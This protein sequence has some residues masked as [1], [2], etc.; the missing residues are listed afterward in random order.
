MKQA[1]I[2]IIYLITA[3]LFT[4]CNSDEHDDEY[5]IPAG[6]GALIVELR[7][8]ALASSIGDIH[9]F[10][11]ESGGKLKDRIY[12]ESPQAVASRYFNFP[13]GYYTVIAVANAGKDFMPDATDITLPGFVAKLT[14]EAGDYPDMISG[15]A[16]ANLSEGEVKRISIV[17]KD[18]ATGISLSTLRLIL[19]LPSPHLP[20]YS[21]PRSLKTSGTTYALRCVIEACRNGSGEILLRHENLPVQSNDGSERYIVELALDAGTHN[22]RIWTDYVPEGTTA[23]HHYIAAGGLKTVTINTDPYRANTDSRNAFYAHLS[24][25][26]LTNEIQE[27]TVTMERPLAKYRL[28]ATDVE[29]YRQLVANNNYPPLD[30]LTATIL[31]EGFVPSS[32]NVTTGSPN[33]AIT[34]L[35]YGS[36]LPMSAAGAE[37]MQVGS[38]WVLVNGSETFVN[39][40]VRI[41]DKQ[42]NIVSQISGVRIN[43]H[44]GYLTTV[45]GQFLTAGKTSGGIHIDT[46]WEDDIIIEF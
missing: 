27:E 39:V 5:T 22:I 21:P 43:Y 32:F 7:L 16:Q 15:M 23:D 36:E 46:D 34:G 24:P 4:A 11:F 37:Q 13:A 12:P 1:Y 45:S 18:G 3:V 19:A 10:V 14:A 35:S 2:Y 41:A 30:E 29:H 40:T 28:I 38:D 17:L 33:D 8:E 25:I 20:E 9:L 31:Y 44:R 26:T 42:G 6:N